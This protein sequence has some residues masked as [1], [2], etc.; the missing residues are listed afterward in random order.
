MIPHLYL[1][2]AVAVLTLTAGFVA[3]V[4]VTN[5]HRDSQ[6]FAIEQAAEKAGKSAAEAAVT[7]IEK[8]EVRNVTIKQQAETVTREVPT[9][10]DCVHDQRVFDGI[11]QALTEPGADPPRLPAADAAHGQ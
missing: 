8:I 7:A 9:Y 5:W 6:Q 2:G 10:R 11:N 1:A 3:G 4:K